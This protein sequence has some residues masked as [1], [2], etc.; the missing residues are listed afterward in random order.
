MDKAQ[1]NIA[2][3]PLVSTIWLEGRL[4]HPNLRIVDCS[5][6]M[7]VDEDGQRNYLSGRNAWTES[8]IPGSAFID[9]LS[10]FGPR[11]NPA[12]PF[13]VALVDFAHAMES[14]GISNHNQVVLYDS[15]NHAWAAC[16]WWLLRL[17]GIDSMILHGGWLKWIT[18]QRSVS[19]EIISY[20]LGKIN[21]GPRLN[22]IAK[23]KQVLQ[24]IN[25]EKTIIINA[26]SADE[27]SGKVKRF[28]RRGRIKGSV[29]VDCSLLV[30]NESHLF[31]P[32]EQLLEIFAASGVTEDNKVITYC[33]GGVAASL[34][35]LALTIIG[36]RDVAIY[37]GSLEEW[38]SDPE[39]PMETDYKEKIK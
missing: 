24:S 22:L 16:I 27:H 23:K 3:S 19:S 21:I 37:S 29:N 32:Q 20:P 14:C 38:A 15:T 30:D 28:T 17:C 13:S 33:G 2:Y 9:I 6:V 31:L 39:L 25:D 10:D 7:N 34:D 26:L 35:A 36:F 11:Y 12:V 1:K 8:H 5:V 18:E 4:D